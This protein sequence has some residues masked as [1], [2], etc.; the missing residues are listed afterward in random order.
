MTMLPTRA[1]VS[2]GT[3]PIPDHLPPQ[4]AAISSGITV[5][6]G[7]VTLDGEAAAAKARVLLTLLQA[8]VD[9]RELNEQRAT[10][11]EVFLEATTG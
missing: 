1:H 11:E 5:T 2:I 4:L 7:R 9:V 3:G 6:D 10:L 8:G